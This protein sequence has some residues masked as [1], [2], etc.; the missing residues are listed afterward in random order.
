[1]PDSAGTE[2][3]RF[4]H[5]DQAYLQWVAAN[6]D[7]FVLDLPRGEPG[8]ALLHRATC[9]RLADDQAGGGW[10]AGSLRLASGEKWRLDDWAEGE[11]GRP[12]PRCQVCSPG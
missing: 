2:V 11:L 12:A 7:G 9:E 3:E 10:T 1:M 8:G 5:D 4:D 6:P